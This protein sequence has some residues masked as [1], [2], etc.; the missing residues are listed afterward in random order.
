VIKNYPYPE[1]T[2]R[3]LYNALDFSGVV[4][5][6]PWLAALAWVKDVFAK[7]QRQSQRPLAE[8]PQTTLPKRLRPYLLTFDADGK[9]TGVC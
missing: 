1:Q 6:N 8:C 4:A 9:P 2:P 7:R 3:P 5:D